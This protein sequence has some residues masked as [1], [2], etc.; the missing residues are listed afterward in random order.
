MD[1]RGITRQN[2]GDLLMEIGKSTITLGAIFGIITANPIFVGVFV[3]GI[4]LIVSG[5]MLRVS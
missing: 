3:S 5:W 1:A 2:A 4:G